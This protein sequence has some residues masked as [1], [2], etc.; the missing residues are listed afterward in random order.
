MWANEVLKAILSILKTGSK[1]PNYFDCT[2]EGLK[3][4]QTILRLPS[5]FIDLKRK[6]KVPSAITKYLKASSEF[7]AIEA[8]K[9]N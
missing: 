2:L 7:I 6:A 8:A 4:V 9:V 5:K 1:I 3:C